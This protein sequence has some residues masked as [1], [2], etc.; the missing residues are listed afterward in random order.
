M[1]YFLSENPDIKAI[2]NLIKIGYTENTVEERTKNAVKDPTFLE[3]PVKIVGAFEC[4]NLNPNRFE[5]L[6]HGVLHAQKL[7]MTLKSSVGKDYHPNE[8]FRVDLAIAKEVATR[9]VDGSIV[10]YRMN[11][12]T[13]RLVKK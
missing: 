5:T 11:N 7:Q 8:W 3:A 9:I 4:F 12:T 6:I 10:Q 2:P 13:G 1:E